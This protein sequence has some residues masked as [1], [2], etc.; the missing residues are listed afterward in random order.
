MII[1]AKVYIE[2]GRVQNQ[3][4]RDARDRVTK[5]RARAVRVRVRVRV[6]VCV[7]VCVCVRECVSG[8]MLFFTV[9]P[10]Y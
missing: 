1:N 10:I 9:Y 3:A 4:K 6:R 5:S 7:C 2:T 8:R